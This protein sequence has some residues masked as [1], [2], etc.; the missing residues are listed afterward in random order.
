[1]IL[2]KIS[3]L[4]LYFSIWQSVQAGEKR[5]DTFEKGGIFFV[6]KVKEWMIYWGIT[7]N[8]CKNFMKYQSQQNKTNHYADN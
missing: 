2:W 4:F 1:M 8:S 7:N 6:L 3:H 5:L